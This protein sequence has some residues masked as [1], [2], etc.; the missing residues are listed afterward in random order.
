MHQQKQEFLT[1]LRLLSCS[2]LESQCLWEARAFRNCQKQLEDDAQQC[3]EAKVFAISL[4]LVIVYATHVCVS[5]NS[6]FFRMILHSSGGSVKVGTYVAN[7][8]QSAPLVMHSAHCYHYE[9]K[10]AKRATAKRYNSTATAA[11]NATSYER[12]QVTTHIDRCQFHYLAF[13]DKTNIPNLYQYQLVI[14][15][16]EVDWEI[17]DE[18][19]RERFEHEKA[20]FF[21]T[22]AHC[23]SH[24][25]FTTYGTMKGFETS[26]LCCVDPDDVPFAIQHGALTFRMMTLL[27]LGWVF[28]V[29]TAGVC[30][31]VRIRF[32]K[33]IV[34]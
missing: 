3:S 10:F 8:C 32:K 1:V 6:S 16:G 11:Q 27:S 28:R 24:H 2:R 20:L 19:V 23:D 4:P 12:I 26:V 14:V 25:D 30:G 33:L 17:M 15:E 13:S 34:Q 29:W 22:H 31:M 7:M 5:F 18:E 21:G 9:E